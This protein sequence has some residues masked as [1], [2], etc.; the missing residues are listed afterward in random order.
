MPD[1]PDARRLRIPDFTY[2]LPDAR[3][4]K[5]PL[6][7]RDHSKLLVCRGAEPLADHRFQ[8]LPALLPARAVLVFNDTRV[9][10]ARLRF[11]KASGTTIEVFCLEP[12]NQALEEA[13]RQTSAATW[14][15]LIGNRKKW[16]DGAALTLPLNSAGEMLTARPVGEA[17]DGQPLVR[18][19]WTPP[20]RTFSEVLEADGKLP[21]P[22]YLHREADAA[23]LTRYQT[24]YARH[25]GAVAAPTAGLHF[26]PAVLAELATRG[27]E[28]LHV[29]LHVG[30]GTFQPV[31]ADEMAGHPMHGELISVSVAA[32]QGLR[33]ALVANRPLLAVGTTSARTL[34][35]VYWL[36]AHLAQ[37]QPWAP[38]VAQWTPY[39]PGAATPSALAAVDALLD[40]LHRTATL[41]LV[42]TTHLLIA[43]GYT[44]QMVQG[45]ITNFHQPE[46]TLLL[47]VAALIGERWREV[48][49]HALAADYRFLSYGDSSLLLP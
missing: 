25:E 39:T 42:A 1:P 19:E 34:E 31:K 35:S 41:A 36:G 20:T 10:R 17:P 27:I 46:S 3:I 24:V 26:T 33:A 2:A 16:R 28:S 32:L 45:L 49:A 18:F 14:R 6:A 47:L 22:P 7:E 29:T 44:F 38:V 9:V 37:G 43:P 13:L 30:A 48:Y 4:A 11:Q 5:H 21:L 40:H 15:C 23:D 8:D 12:D